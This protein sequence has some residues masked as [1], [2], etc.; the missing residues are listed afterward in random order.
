MEALNALGI[1]RLQS[2][3]LEMA[4]DC[5]ERA[6]RLSPD[7]AKYHNNLGN[8]QMARETYAATVT[9]FER[10]VLL[11][12]ENPEFLTNAATSCWRAG[13][14]AEAERYFLA[15]LTLDSGHYRANHNLGA[16]LSQQS[17][18][19]DALPYLE[20]AAR[21]PNCDVDTFL[22][23]ASAYERL[24]RLAA[25][26]AIVDQI[27][28]TEHPRMI[29]LRARLLRRR[30]DAAAALELLT[31]AHDRI[32][33]EAL[34]LEFGGEWCHEIMLCADLEGKPELAFENLLAVKSYRRR[35]SGEGGGEV[36]LEDVRRLRQKGQMTDQPAD[37]GR[38]NGPKTQTSPAQ[39]L[40]VGF[41]RS[42]TTLLEVILNSHPAI[43]TTDEAEI[44]ASV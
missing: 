23:L 28:E 7:T 11:D 43:V 9:A 25:A 22:N 35:A 21:E 20:N 18:L 3:R 16:L 36:F 34:G 37:R 8:V 29:F 32:D 26:A 4:L 2:G 13:D 27:V 40:F 17:R 24:N 6:V 12:P 15:V 19:G 31:E 41:P 30:G 44:L 10:A 39:V 33:F 42:G 5:F 14:G 38:E 1:L